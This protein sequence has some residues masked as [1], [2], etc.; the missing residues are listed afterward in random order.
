MKAG[1]EDARKRWR[2]T[3]RREAVTVPLCVTYPGSMRQ[4]SPATEKKLD[5]AHNLAYAETIGEG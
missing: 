2:G 5:A 1:A 3:G 4:D